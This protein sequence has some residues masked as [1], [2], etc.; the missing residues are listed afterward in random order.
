VEGL[1]NK[2]YIDSRNRESEVAAEDSNT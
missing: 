1:S 2:N